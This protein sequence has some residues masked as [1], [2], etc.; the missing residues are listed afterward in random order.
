MKIL[1]NGTTLTGGGGLQVGRSLVL[2]LAKDP[3][4]HVIKN[5]VSKE[6]ADVL[7]SGVD[8][9]VVSPSPARPISGA[10]SRAQLRKIER[11][12]APD[13]VLTIFGPSYWKPAAAHVCGFADPWVFTSNRHAW[14]LL[15]LINKIKVKLKCTGKHL[16]LIREHPDAFIVEIGFLKDKLE[17]RF[18]NSEVHVV[19]NNCGQ[20]FFELDP[21]CCP[22]NNPVVPS[23]RDG[24]FRIVTLSKYYRHKC[25]DLIPKVAGI[26]ND[27]MPDVDFR[28]VVSLDDESEE[29]RRL[30]DAARERGVQDR[31]VTVG[32][33]RPQEAPCFYESAD[34]M[35]LPSVLECFS[36]NYP[37]AMRMSV[38]IVTTDLPFARNVCQE[39]ALYFEPLNEV[40]AADKIIELYSTDGLRNT[41]TSKG[42]EI[43]DALP[44]PEEKAS[45][46]IKVCET[47]FGDAR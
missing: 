3:R 15:N 5:V 16:A 9:S 23:K 27:R 4:G 10:R 43:A 22:R 26:L 21:L 17:P 44:T 28:F 2:E 47:V 36:A 46:Y 13:V 40:S 32:A 33:V 20:A 1:A 11:E 19:Q 7:P 24:E 34:A 30:A 25:L 12:F 18:K 41:L 6:F 14:T 38:P 29:W 37:E 8:V 42:H 35:L 31:V 39:A 45:Q